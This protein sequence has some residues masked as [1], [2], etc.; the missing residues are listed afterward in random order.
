MLQAE[1]VNAG[2]LRN[3]YKFPTPGTVLPLNITNGIEASMT[4]PQ[5]PLLARANSRLFIIAIS[6]SAIIK[7]FS[8][9]AGNDTLSMV[10]ILFRNMQSFLP[11]DVSV[12]HS[13]LA[14]KECRV[15]ISYSSQNV[16]GTSEPSNLMPT[17]R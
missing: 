17:C 6:E 12:V 7:L 15:Y 2:S 1:S 4:L 8:L 3:D 11:R 9:L 5:A 16:S 13:S 14:L 10:H